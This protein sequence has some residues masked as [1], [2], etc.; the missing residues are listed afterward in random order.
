MCP[1]PVSRLPPVLTGSQVRKH[2]PVNSETV[3]LLC[4]RTHPCVKTGTAGLM[5]AASGSYDVAAWEAELNALEKTLKEC[6]KVRAKPLVD[7]VLTLKRAFKAFDF[8]DS[9]QIEYKEFVRALEKFGMSPTPAVRGLFDR[10]AQVD[11]NANGIS[12]AE[13]TAG[14]FGEAK[15]KPPVPPKPSRDAWFLDG[16]FRQLRTAPAN[17][18]QGSSAEKIQ[19][20]ER[21]VKAISITS[22]KWRTMAPPKWEPGPDGTWKQ[23]PGDGTWKPT[24]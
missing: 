7:E 2:V 21:V 6:L 20:P 18:W 1:S 15:N 23:S 10:Y 24:R 16:D 11:G 17:S 3:E 13:F 8:N 9:G 14:F 4:R 19:S 12:Y 5:A 22:E